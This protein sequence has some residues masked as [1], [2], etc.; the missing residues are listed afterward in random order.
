VKTSK[1]YSN[2]D[3]HVLWTQHILVKCICHG[4]SACY[5][6]HITP[7]CHKYKAL[8]V[9]QQPIVSSARSTSSTYSSLTCLA[10]EKLQDHAE[11]HQVLVLQKSTYTQTERNSL[12]RTSTNV[13]LA[14]SAAAAVGHQS[15]LGMKIL[16]LGE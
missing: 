6:W 3:C 13:T 2:L 4:H 7:T 9:I 1:S 11:Q 14:T 10:V 8:L 16:N 12:T 5:M 15:L